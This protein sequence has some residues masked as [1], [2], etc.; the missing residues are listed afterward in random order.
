[1]PVIG[2]LS[3]YHQRDV[4]QVR[5]IVESRG[6][7]FDRR[8]EYQYDRLPALAAELVR[9]RVGVIVTSGGP[10]THLAAKSATQTIPIVFATGT[11]P[12]AFGLVAS[13]S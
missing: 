2:Y 13:L 5:R 8:A 10:A 7:N 1:M 9:R 11:D 3:G 6:R 12:V 4:A